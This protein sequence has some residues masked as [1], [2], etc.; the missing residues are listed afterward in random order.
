MWE[1][2][3]FD[4]P[5]ISAGEL[6]ISVPADKIVVFSSDGSILPHQIDELKI[7][8]KD[9]L[10]S[11]TRGDGIFD[12][13]DEL[14]FPARYCSGKLESKRINELKGIFS[15]IFEI[16]LYDS[17]DK[18]FCYIGILRDSTG[19]KIG[20]YFEGKIPG[21]NIKVFDKGN[22]LVVAQEDIRYAVFDNSKPVVRSISAKDQSGNFVEVFLGLEARISVELFNLI[23]IEKTHEDI[24]AKTIFVKSGSVR[25]IRSIRPYADI[26]FG[27]KIPGANITSYIYKGF[28]YVENAVPIPFNLSYISRQAYADIYLK[29]LKAKKF[30]S[31]EHNVEL[32]G[33]EKLQED[34]HM[35]GY[36][37]ADIYKA[38]YFIKE[39]T[40]IPISRYLYFRNSSEVLKVGITLDIL[41]LPRGEHRFALYGFF[42]PPGD[43][44]KAKKVVNDPL[45]RNIIKI[46]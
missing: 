22:Y 26:G 15:S 23:K 31:R 46:F 16:E 14:V 10:K 12:G 35:W 39:L 8:G 45:A 43:I 36:I 20:K 7:E 13:Y 40:P 17:E 1:S 6:G 5:V 44:E 37:E 25:A 9:K 38:A 30:I 2:R 19:E 3:F 34:G 4:Y 18:K 32:D 33:T 24:S 27:I 11:Y 41:K 28:M 42:M 21:E 29:F